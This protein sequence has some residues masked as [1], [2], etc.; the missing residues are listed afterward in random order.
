MI[1]SSILLTILALC[2]TWL[3]ANQK[4]SGFYWWIAS[5]S[6]WSIYNLIIGQYALAGLFAVYLILAIKGLMTWK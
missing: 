2:G 4:R 3:N 6:G 1:V 5:N